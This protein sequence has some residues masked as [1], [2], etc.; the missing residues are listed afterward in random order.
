MIYRESDWIADVEIVRDLSDNEWHKLELKVI[1]TIQPSRIYKPT[2]DGTIFTCCERK[3]CLGMA[4]WFL[5][6]D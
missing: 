2:S 4:G 3:D 5:E 1:R 6:E